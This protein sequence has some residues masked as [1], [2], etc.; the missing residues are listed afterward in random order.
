MTVSTPTNPADASAETTTEDVDK[1]ISTT[2]GEQANY[3][4]VSETEKSDF[5][6][7]DTYRANEQAREDGAG[8][9]L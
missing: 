6:E 1:A 3:D 7:A 4:K 9:A 2:P 8:E 5:T